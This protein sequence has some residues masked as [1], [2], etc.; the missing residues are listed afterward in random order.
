MDLPYPVDVADA[1]RHVR[2]NVSERVAH[3]TGMRATECTLD[4]AHL[5]PADGLDKRR[6]Q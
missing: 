5:V 4:L 2:R 1:L 3:L 6:V